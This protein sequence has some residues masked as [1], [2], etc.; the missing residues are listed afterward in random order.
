M[1]AIWRGET[2]ISGLINGKEYDIVSVEWDGLA[3]NV[4]GEIGIE[5]LFPVEDFDI[6]EE[7]C[8]ERGDKNVP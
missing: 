5:F 7:L 2:T 4:V 6:S 3:F 8:S 1:K